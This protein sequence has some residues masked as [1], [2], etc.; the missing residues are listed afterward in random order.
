MKNFLNLKIIIAIVIDLILSG[1]AINISNYIRLNFY[2]LIKVETISACLLLPLVFISLGIYKRPWKYFSIDDLWSLVKACLLANIL[3]FLVIFIFNRLE[4]IPRLV[5]ILNLFIL[6]F[7]TGSTRI[8]YRTIF[9]KFAFLSYSDKTRIPTLLIGA[10]DN[11]DLFIRAT[12][13]TDSIYNVIGILDID[14]NKTKEFLIRGV[15]V[16]GSVKDLDKIIDKLQFI[17][18][19]PQKIIITSNGLNAKDMSNLMKIVD[20]KGMTIGR[21][22]SPNQLIE[23]SSSNSQV[24]DISIED[25]LGRRQNKLEHVKMRSFLK[26]QTVLITGAGGSIG[27]E[28]ARTIISLGLKKLILLDISE[29]SI[30]NLANEL[31]KQVQQKKIIL[32]CCNLGNS[33]ELEKVFIKYNP[34]IVYHAAAMKHVFICEE[35]PTEAIRTNIFG[36]YSLANLSEKYKVKCFV[37]ISTDKA[38]NPSS[39]M[40]ATKKFAESIIQSKDCFSTSV[41]RFIT[42]RFGNVLGSQGSVVPLFK[43]QISDG[44]PVTVTD[45]DV[46]R[47][48]MTINEAVALVLNATLEQYRAS[49]GLRGSVSVLNMGASIKIDILAKQM[50]K[51]AGFVPNKQIKIVYTGLTK[52]EKLHESLYSKAEQKVEIGEKGFFLVKS[53]LSNRQDLKKKLDSLKNSYNYSKTGTKSHLLKLI[54]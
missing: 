51:L 2:D 12:E 15:S 39:V 43:K 20:A 3:I 35:N 54:K 18:K 29:N 25:L 49:T 48:F 38:V 8:I 4:N 52:G 10:G 53:K 13:R 45:K 11:A 41:T 22:Q 21:A 24:K 47:F 5:T 31:K 23:G 32:V 7:V 17:K 14:Q 9:E 36:T 16:L 37:L 6:V 26:N 1:L 50:I 46:T 28:L 27:S 42:V 30:F 40:G 19:N 34:N 33:D 44:G